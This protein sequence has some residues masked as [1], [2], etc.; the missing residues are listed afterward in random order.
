MA[1]DLAILNSYL[2]GVAYQQITVPQNYKENDLKDII[3]DFDKYKLMPCVSAITG[4]ELFVTL[5]CI[6]VQQALGLCD[7]RTIN[8]IGQTVDNY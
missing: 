5:E 3:K 8:I 4:A 7:E 6:L 1:S 2:R